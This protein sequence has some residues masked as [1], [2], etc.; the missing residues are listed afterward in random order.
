MDRLYI[1]E[2]IFKNN[3]YILEIFD[4]NTFK[5]I[6]E[7]VKNIKDIFKNQFKK[8]NIHIFN[9]KNKKN[10]NIIINYEILDN[11]L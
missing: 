5:T 1:I 4:K 6:K 8:I 2:I 10:N 11:E 9:I 7:E 3:D